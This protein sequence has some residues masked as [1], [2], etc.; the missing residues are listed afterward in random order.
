MN[1]YWS[2][3]SFPEL[4]D[5]PKERRK[6]IW[7]A[8][9]RKIF[10]HWQIWFFILIQGLL[11][12]IIIETV[13]SY[14]GSSNVIGS[15]LVMIFGGLVGGITYFFIQ[16]IERSDIREYLKSNENPN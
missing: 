3:N 9:R 8:G 13:K 7:K 11:A 12:V 5:V 16:P 6:E 1:I 10:H 15:I 4:K 14:F 2:Y